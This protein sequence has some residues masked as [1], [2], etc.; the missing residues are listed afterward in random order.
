MSEEHKAYLGD[1]VYG[2]LDFHGRV[3]L[4][5]ENGLEAT[6]TVV[7]EPEV[8]AKLEKWLAELRA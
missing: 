7:L 1:G 8:L 2:N 3:V 4:T 5:T 6:N